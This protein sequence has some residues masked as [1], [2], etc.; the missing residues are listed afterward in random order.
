MIPVEY[1]SNLG[2]R[3]ISTETDMNYLHML[4]STGQPS[5]MGKSSGSSTNILASL[6]SFNSTSKANYASNSNT[7]TVVDINITINK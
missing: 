3:T 4:A 7:N 2:I 1:L 6:G 5:F